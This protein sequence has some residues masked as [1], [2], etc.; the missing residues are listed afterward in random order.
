[1][2]SFFSL[3]WSSVG[4]KYLMAITGLAW[5]GFAVGH[6]LGNLALFAGGEAFNKYAHFL[7]GLGALLYVA[8][9]GLVIL[10]LTHV[11]SA[12]RVTWTNWGARGRAYLVKDDAGG[13]SRKT[14]SSRTMIYTG[15]VIFLFLVVHVWMFKYGAY[16][17]TQVQGVEMRDLYRLVVERFG[18]PWI[19]GGYVAVM[20]FLGFHLRHAFWS[21]F[22]SLGLNH[23]RWSSAIYALGVILAIGLALGFVVLPIWV[24]LKGGVV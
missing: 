6:L 18:N 13:P 22:Q 14:L 1:M 12:L 2:R 15:I 24:Y 21:A 3:V 4:Q 5:I 7:Q 11:V 10:L 19:S 23:P 9:A 16:Y 20:L 8:E 17:S